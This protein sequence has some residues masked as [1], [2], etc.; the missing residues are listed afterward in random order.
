MAGTAA[1]EREFDRWLAP[2]WDALGDARRR[3]W[4]PV[5]VRGLLGASD[6]K[7]VEPMAARVAPDDYG[8][9]HHFVCASC[10]PPEPL[11]RV[12]AEKAQHLVGGPDAVLIVDDTALLKQ[13]RHSVGVARQY[14]GSAGKTTNCQTLVSLTLARARCPLASRCGSSCRPSGPTT[15]SGVAR[16]ACPTPGSRIARS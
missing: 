13:G 12:L 3:R 8:Q 4:G 9:L 5:Y 2:F 6:R 10:W 14:A 1:W 16:P 11:E 15:A 7:S